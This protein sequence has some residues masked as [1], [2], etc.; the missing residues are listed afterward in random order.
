MRILRCKRN[1]FDRDSLNRIIQFYRNAIEQG[2]PDDFLQP[3]QMELNYF[4]RQQNLKTNQSISVV[5]SLTTGRLKQ[6][7]DAIPKHIIRDINS[8]SNLRDDIVNPFGG[9]YNKNRTQRIYNKHKKSRKPKKN[10]KRK[11]KRRKINKL[12]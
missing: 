12:M 10:K 6:E 5:N 11:T 9:K 1:D 4:I 7:K 3:F 2:F 8:L